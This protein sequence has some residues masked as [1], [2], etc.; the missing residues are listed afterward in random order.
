[1]KEQTTAIEIKNLSKRYKL[2]IRDSRDVLRLLMMNS[3]SRFHWALKD[4]SLAIPKGKTVG[5]VGPNGAGKSTLLKIL[6]RITTPTNGSFKVYGKIASLLEAGVGF[7]PE[8]TGIENVILQGAYLGMN[9][10]EVKQR[11]PEIISFAGLDEYA[12]TP[13]KRYSSGMTLRLATSS[14]LHLDA[15][16]LLLDEILSVADV[17]FRD[18]YSKSLEGIGKTKAKTILF[19]SHNHDLL[20]QSCD[21]GI[22][23][24]EG[25]AKYYDNFLDCL[26]AYKQKIEM[27]E[28]T[29]GKLPIIF[30]TKTAEYEIVEIEFDNPQAF[31]PFSINVKYNVIK[32]SNKISIGLALMNRGQKGFSLSIDSG[33][34]GHTLSSEVGRFE[35]KVTYPYLPCHPGEYE[36]YISLWNGSFIE[37]VSTQKLL[38][39]IQ[40]NQ[41]SGSGQKTGFHVC[42]SNFENHRL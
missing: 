6:S 30:K 23:V 13:I 42:P 39:N 21:S 34:T 38:I 20:S 35:M 29:K 28:N 3:N 12:Q 24:W 22:L 33:S 4:I 40:G 25:K 37:E 32:P 18:K 26:N 1:M 11:M 19:V 7:H 31:K 9:A 16:I 41:L 8:Y 27:V 36:L 14:A 2:G 10:Q 5:V 17:S 15:D